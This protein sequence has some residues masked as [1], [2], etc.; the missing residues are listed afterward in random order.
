V[1]RQMLLNDPD[2]LGTEALEWYVRQG[3]RAA[4]MPP[5]RRDN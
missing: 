3:L 4:L 5:E 2:L 1:M